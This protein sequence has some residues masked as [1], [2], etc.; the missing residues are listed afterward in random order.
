MADPMRWISYFILAYV[1]VGLQMGLAGAMQVHGARPNLVLIAVVFIALN[2]P[3]D[4]ALLGAF[5]LG[6][7]Q[8]LTSQGALGLYAFSYGVVALMVV[9]TQQVALRN[10][11]LTHVAMVLIGGMITALVLTLH[12]W[13]RPP[14]MSELIGGAHAIRPA[15]GPFFSSAVYSAVLAPILIWGILQR[16]RGLFHFQSSRRR[17]PAYR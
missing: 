4:A 12:A 11:P 1:M 8:D 13:L 16:M 5:I 7:M 17:G 15:V 3:R 6:A 9:S 2:A 10:H 14:P